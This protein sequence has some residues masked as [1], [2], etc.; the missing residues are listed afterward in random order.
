VIGEEI[1]GSVR[2]LDFRAD[3]SVSGK[4]LA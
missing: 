3:P 4:Q 2:E 1:D